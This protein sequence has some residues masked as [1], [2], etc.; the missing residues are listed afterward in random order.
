MCHYS[1][2]LE[3]DGN[4]GSNGSKFAEES[5]DLGVYV[6]WPFWGTWRVLNSLFSGKSLGRFPVGTQSIANPKQGASGQ[7]N[8]IQGDVGCRKKNS[9]NMCVGQVQPLLGLLFCCFVH[10]S[11]K[12]RPILTWG[13]RRRAPSPRLLPG[14][15]LQ[16][17][18]TCMFRR[19]CQGAVLH[20]LWW[21]CSAS[22]WGSWESCCKPRA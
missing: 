20:S 7:H 2:L 10:A 19:C 9:D 16:H 15:R 13:A 5:T 4:A 21:P 8:E 11:S 17:R 1:L 12:L 6:D 3:G 22:S 14:H 18:G